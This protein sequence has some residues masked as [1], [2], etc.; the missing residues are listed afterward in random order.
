MRISLYLSVLY[1]GFASQTN[2]LFD[3]FIWCLVF[4]IMAVVTR[5]ITTIHRVYLGRPSFT[6]I[7]KHNY[8]CD[9]LTS[10]IINNNNIFFALKKHYPVKNNN[11]FLFSLI[12]AESIFIADTHTYS[13]KSF[14][15][16]CGENRPEQVNP[17]KMEQVLSLLEIAHYFKCFDQDNDHSFS[18]NNNY[19][20]LCY[21]VYL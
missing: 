1:V 11:F 17:G 16:A 9:Q 8:N 2:C 4:I 7:L 3:S 18:L 21:I 10:F 20:I 12:T 13:S 14:E 19:Y 6:C 15:E 5:K